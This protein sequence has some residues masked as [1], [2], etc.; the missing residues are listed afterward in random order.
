[1]SRGSWLGLV[2]SD[3]GMFG[4]DRGESDVVFVDQVSSRVHTLPLL[5]RIALGL[6]R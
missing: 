1:M 5:L 3:W 4:I 2:F 6:E